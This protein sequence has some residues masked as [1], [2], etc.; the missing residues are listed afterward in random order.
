MAA[1][2]YNLGHVDEVW[3]VPCGTRTDKKLS[4]DGDHR[5]TMV[6]III[7]DMFPPDFPLKVNI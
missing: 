4:L 2:A 1:E 7:K 6:N 3:I 5:L